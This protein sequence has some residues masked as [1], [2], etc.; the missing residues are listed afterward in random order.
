M[1]MDDPRKILAR[2]LELHRDDT[3]GDELG[4]IRAD[5]MT[6]ENPIRLRMRD[7]FH[8]TRGLIHRNSAAD[9]GERE[10]SRLVRNA[11]VLALLLGLADPRDLGFRVDDPRNRLHVH[12]PRLAR[13]DL[14]DG[15]AF[16]ESLVREHRPAHAVA[17]GPDAFDAGPAM[18]VDFDAA[19][20]I[21]P[22]A[23]AFA[24]RAGRERATADRDEQLVDGELLLAVLRRVREIDFVALDLG[25]RELRAEL[26]L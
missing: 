11:F 16:L 22:D 6:A 24:E 8:E 23:S 1:R 25:L 3:L 9:G 5:E 7:D 10:R 15:D 19:T 2:T 4:N 26:D 12:V 21:E 13:D 20:L 14:G 18:L 17:D